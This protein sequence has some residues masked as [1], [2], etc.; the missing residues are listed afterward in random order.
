[1]HRLQIQVEEKTYGALRRRAFA[2][3]VSMGAVVR[4]LLESA[5]GER[6]SHNLKL[7]DFTFVGASSSKDSNRISEEHD[8]ALGEK[9]W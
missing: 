2:R 1:M 7:A 3:R 8:G 4:D 5:L 6:P 9:T